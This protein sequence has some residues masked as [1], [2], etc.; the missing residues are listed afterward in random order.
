MATRDEVYAA[1]NSE[2]D[3]QINT[4]GPKAKADGK[5]IFTSAAGNE[6]ARDAENYILYMEHYLQEARR[7]ASTCAGGS[8]GFQ[9]ALDFV[10]KVAGLAVCCMEQHGAPPRKLKYRGDAGC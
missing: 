9:S 2:R 6:P 3:Y 10:R 7:L 5:P 8:D 1:I 4:W